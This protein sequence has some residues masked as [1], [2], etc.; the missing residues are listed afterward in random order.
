GTSS[1][2]V[3]NQQFGRNYTFSTISL[4][5]TNFV[6]LTINSTLITSTWIL[7]SGGSWTSGTNW[8]TNPTIP[9]TAGAT[10]VFGGVITAPQVVTLDGNKTVGAIVFSNTNAYTIA[11][12]TGSGTLTLDNSTSA[13]SITSSTG[14]HIIGVPVALSSSN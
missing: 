2:S 12:G 14:S 1:L 13:A 5:G 7:N 9:N 4:G 10:A 3:L 11:S 8:D 6:T